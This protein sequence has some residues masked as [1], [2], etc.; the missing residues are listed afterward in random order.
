M[1]VIGSDSGAIPDVIGPGGWIVPEQDPSALAA[2]LDR[3]ADNPS[4]LAA[5][6]E[7]A[8]CHASS[9]FTYDR[10]AAAL[11]QGFKSGCQVRRLLMSAG[12]P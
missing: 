4:E 8:Y 10:I 9:R 2:C 12:Q 7:A 5:V 3:L 1:P 6:A 11:K